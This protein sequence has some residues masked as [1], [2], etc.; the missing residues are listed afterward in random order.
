M[1]NPGCHAD[2]EIF[3]PQAAELE[4]EYFNPRWS[5]LKL[6]IMK[7]IEMKY[8]A[9]IHER[10]GRFDYLKYY[11]RLGLKTPRLLSVVPKG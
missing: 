8:P 5:E 3:Q 11:D 2:T 9:I 7:S 1:S 4:P 6:I 10:Q